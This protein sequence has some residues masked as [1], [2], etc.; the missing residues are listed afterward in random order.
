[1]GKLVIMGEK[2]VNYKGIRNWIKWIE[3]V[4]GV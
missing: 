2:D 1:M 4:Y 3:Y